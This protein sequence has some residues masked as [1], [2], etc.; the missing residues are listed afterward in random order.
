MDRRQYNNIFNKKIVCKIYEFK[1]F[2]YIGYYLKNF[3][4]M[5]YIHTHADIC[6]IKCI[7][8]SLY[9]YYI[10]YIK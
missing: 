4:G 9:I 10:L 8:I 1:I 5:I 6:A 7:I 2:V 3:Y